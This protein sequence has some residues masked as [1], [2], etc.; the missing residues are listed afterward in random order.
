MS[1]F[2]IPQDEYVQPGSE[3]E[4]PESEN[5]MRDLDDI[6][7]ELEVM[8]VKMRETSP[9]M[10]QEVL[11]KEYRAFLSLFK[12]ALKAAAHKHGWS[13]T[14]KFV[15]WLRRSGVG[16]WTVVVAKILFGLACTVVFY[17]LFSLFLLPWI[18]QLLKQFGW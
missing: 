18:A 4:T 7:D 3:T 10:E 17:I 2:K 5:E 9:F 8:A 14:L 15:D 12:E 6:K 16:Y 1:E 11:E 13:R